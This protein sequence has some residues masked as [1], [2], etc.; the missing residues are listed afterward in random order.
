[1][2]SEVPSVIVH[3]DAQWIRA[4]KKL[5]DQMKQEVRK[6]LGPESPDLVSYGKRYESDLRK[7]WRLSSKAELL[8]EIER[9]DL[10]YGGDFHAFGQA[11]RTHLKILRGISNERPVLLALECF[12]SRH[13]KWL[14]AFLQDEI[15]LEVLRVKT[16]WERE[17]GFPWESYRPLLELAKRRGFRL[18]ALNTNPGPRSAAI[19][20]ARDRE[21]ARL[22]R[23]AYLRHPH[24]LI[25]VI[26]GDLHLADAHL[27]MAVRRELKRGQNVR[28]IVVH[29]NSE[30]IYFQLAAKAL[31]LTT[32]VVR[33]GS[34]QFCV[35]SSPPWIQWQS[36]LLF[37]EKTVDQGLEDGED[38][39]SEYDHTDQVATMIRLAGRDLELEFKVD[40]LAIYSSDDNRLWQHIETKLKVNEREMARQLLTSGRSFFLPRGGVGYL[41]RSTVNHAAALA[42]QYIHARLCRRMRPLWKFPND[43]PALIWSEA[44]AF[45]ISKLINHK[46][47][48]ETLVDLKAQLAMAGPEEQG[49]EA[50]KLALE[51]RLREMILLRQGRRR[52][53]QIRPRR[54]ASYV[55]AARIL[56]SMMGERLYLAHRS[57]RIKNKEL[58]QLLKL[59]VCGRDFAR[60]YEG[61]LRKLDPSPGRRSLLDEQ[62]GIKTKKERL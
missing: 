56:G 44:A 7:R 28:D 42:G 59:D 51:Q 50:M 21:A 31:D 36:Y 43:F 39:D 57:R 4:R 52:K 17:W 29:L 40:D 8:A 33:L 23:G 25:Y 47:Q 5:V 35:L 32:D 26:F 53:L 18:L 6:R 37:L 49:R 55:E 62:A 19:L 3:P 10:V 61:I 1:M 38:W 16:R 46:R 60:R 27:P 34:N 24:S 58:I 48:S 54:R 11:Q 20:R 15:S 22:L 13:Q 2:K 12:H 45:F 14:D 41:S 9:A 30:R